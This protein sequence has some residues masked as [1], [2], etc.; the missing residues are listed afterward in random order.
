[1]NPNEIQPSSSRPASSQGGT[2]SGGMNQAWIEGDGY[3]YLDSAEISEVFI[4]GWEELRYPEWCPHCQ[5]RHAGY[6]VVISIDIDAWD[7]II[8]QNQCS[9]EEP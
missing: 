4:Q 6:R 8:F 3:D 5:R 1:M 9:E 2:F 7:D